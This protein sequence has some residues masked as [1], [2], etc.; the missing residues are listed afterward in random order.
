MPGVLASAYAPR[1]EETETSRSPGLHG[2]LAS[3]LRE[4]ETCPKGLDSSLNIYIYK[5]STV[6]PYLVQVLVDV[7]CVV[8]V[9]VER[10]LCQ[11][12]TSL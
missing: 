10:R 2:N 4:Y 8:S 12:N 6:F 9:V 5:T 1:T 3:P 11:A 7:K